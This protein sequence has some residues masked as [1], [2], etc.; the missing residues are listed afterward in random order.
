MSWDDDPQPN[1]KAASVSGTR[2]MARRHSPK[3]LAELEITVETPLVRGRRYE[4]RCQNPSPPRYETLNPD[5]PFRS[6]EKQGP[7]HELD[8]P[9]NPIGRIQRPS[10]E[11]YIDDDEAP[12]ERQ[13]FGHPLVFNFCL[14]FGSISITWRRVANCR[15]DWAGPRNNRGSRS[16]TQKIRD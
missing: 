16:R 12:F 6:R 13:V 7:S 3:P 4:T 9:T 15:I 14:S 5:M 11:L 1:E 10:L 8:K 2:T